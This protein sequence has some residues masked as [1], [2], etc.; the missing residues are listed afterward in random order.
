MMAAVLGVTVP[1]FL[2]VAV[3]YVYGRFHSDGMDFVNRINLNLFIPALM[4]FVLSEKIPADLQWG[5]IMLGAAIVVL[6]SGL[7]AWPVAKA[8][9]MPIKALVP[10]AMMNNCG[11]LGL[12]LTL[13]AFGDAGL[14]LAVVT[15]VIYVLL[16]FTVGIWLVSGRLDL[17]LMIRNPI[18]IATALGFGFYLGGL[19]APAMIL[20]GVEM[21]SDV[22][23]P[24][25]LVALGVRLTEVDLEYWRIGL[26]GAVLAP[27]TGL[28]CAVA[29]IWLLGLDTLTAKVLILFGAL[30][31]AVMN[32]LMAERYNAHPSEVATIVSFG[33]IAALGVIP[34][35]LYFIL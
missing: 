6:G 22:A 17:S 30:P 13:L 25:M 28:I 21:L 5:G 32:Y 9:N 29:A 24:L 18:V 7:L 15:F 1:I 4:F 26:T 2:I 14:P 35:V 3:G 20:P 10:T 27:A 11:N 34:A 16:H 23:I 33:N 31:P 8:L 19:H 12:P